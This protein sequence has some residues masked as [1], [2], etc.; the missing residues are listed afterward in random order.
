MTLDRHLIGRQRGDA[1]RSLIQIGKP[2]GQRRPYAASRLNGSGKLG[3]V[4]RRKHDHGD[5]WIADF[6]LSHRDAHG[7]VGIDEM[8]GFPQHGADGRRGLVLV[9]AISGERGADP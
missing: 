6:L 4:G 2:S 9:G 1:L 7:R 8:P 3:R 5:Q